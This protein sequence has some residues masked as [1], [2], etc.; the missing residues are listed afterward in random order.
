MGGVRPK[1]TIEDDNRLWVGKFPE[2]V[3][4][5]N[6][7][8]VE[9]ATTKLAAACGIAACNVR[10]EPIGGRDVLLVE[11]FDREHAEGGYRRFG[12]VSGL[13]LLGCDEGYVDRER[14]SCPLLADELRRCSE[15]PGEDRGELE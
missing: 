9:Y 1:A 7:Q 8:R 10:L 5:F 14:W 3:D 6:L 15:K 2:K 13:T 11:R 12:L 4:R